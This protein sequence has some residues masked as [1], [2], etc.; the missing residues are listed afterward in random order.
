MRKSFRLLIAILMV[1]AAMP[2]LALRGA[3]AAPANNV[4]A[5]P[6]SQSEGR[7]QPEKFRR[8]GKP[9]KDH[10]IVVLKSETPGEEVEAVADELRGRHGG[11]TKHIYSH[12]IKGFSIEMTEAAALALSRDPRVEYVQEDARVLGRWWH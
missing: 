7:G 8:S 5:T 1:V 11:V 2:L 4:S 3:T 9:V 6:Q 12:A 10:Y